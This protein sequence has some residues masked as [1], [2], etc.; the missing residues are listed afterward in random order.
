MPS[1]PTAPKMP[2]IPVPVRGNVD[3][4]HETLMAMKQAT[5]MM[6]GTRNDHPTT[7]TFVQNT[8]PHAYNVGDQWIVAN[9]GKLNYWNGSQWLPVP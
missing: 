7:R 3:S 8:M 4:I 1:F 5:E 6:M 9:T 2:S